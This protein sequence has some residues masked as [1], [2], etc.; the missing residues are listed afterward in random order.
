M[1][2][3]APK[4]G[5]S[6][7]QLW[8]HWI[9]F[10]L[11]IVQWLSGDGAARALAALARQQSPGWLDFALINLHLCSGLSIFTLVLWRL[12]LRWRRPAGVVCDPPGPGRTFARLI[13]AALYLTLVLLPLTGLAAYYALLAAA[14][15]WHNVI[16][17]WF[18]GLLGLHL[19]GF[20]LHFFR[21]HSAW[22][23][24]FRTD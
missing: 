14:P 24:M 20:L 4:S 9:V 6:R 19:A 1:S 13:H 12:R 11:V 10:G 5:Y 16:G 21:G 17:W 8:L 23:R 2:T 7:L 15:H 18:F 22:R 3:V